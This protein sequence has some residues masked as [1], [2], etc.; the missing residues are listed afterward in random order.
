MRSPVGSRESSRVFARA[1][2]VVSEIGEILYLYRLWVLVLIC[3]V[4]VL[5]WDLMR[6]LSLSLGPSCL[7]LL[8]CGVS[9]QLG[10]LLSLL[11]A[12][13]VYR[14]WCVSSYFIGWWG[15]IWLYSQTWCPCLNPLVKLHTLHG[16][17][18]PIG[19]TI[20]LGFSNPPHRGCG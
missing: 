14:R 19:V 2:K 6:A 13:V 5:S 3:Y 18:V 4:L 20:L 1:P 12:Q 10:R 7:L 11:V 9:V 15:N 8:L 16:S 17:V